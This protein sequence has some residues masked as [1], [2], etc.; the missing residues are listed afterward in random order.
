MTEVFGYICVIDDIKN[1]LD[2]NS[3]VI[4]DEAAVTTHFIRS[5]NHELIDYNTII[6][7]VT[8]RIL[9]II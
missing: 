2:A 8:Y 9:K 6:L 7:Y 3:Q 5:T 1:T 4:D